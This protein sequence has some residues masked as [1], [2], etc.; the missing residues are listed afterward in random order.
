MIYLCMQCMGVHVC[1]MAYIYVLCMGVYHIT[2]KKSN[3][4][5]TSNLPLLH[6]C[7]SSVL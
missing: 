6:V 4:Y 7:M 2:D 1:M 5:F 3:M